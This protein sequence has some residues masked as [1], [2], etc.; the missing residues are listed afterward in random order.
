M[1]IKK[2]D[3]KMKS[4]IKFSKVFQAALLMILIMLWPAYND[5][6]AMKKVDISGYAKQEVSQTL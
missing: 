6:C 2:G 1:L 5:V 4:N 3:L